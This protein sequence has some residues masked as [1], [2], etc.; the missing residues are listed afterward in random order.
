MKD[1]ASDGPPTETLQPLDLVFEAVTAPPAPAAE[2]VAELLPLED[3][4]LVA[5]ATPPVPPVPTEDPPSPP[6]APV[7]LDELLLVET[8]DPPVGAQHCSV[9]GPGHWPGVDT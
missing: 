4:A 1:R 5:E 9:A 2:L 8:E 6:P 3:E 7:V